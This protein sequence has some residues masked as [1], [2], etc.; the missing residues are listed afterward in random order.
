MFLDLSFTAP[1]FPVQAPESYI[2][3]YRDA[4]ADPNRLLYAGNTPYELFRL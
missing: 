3:M 4:I 1:H 2:A